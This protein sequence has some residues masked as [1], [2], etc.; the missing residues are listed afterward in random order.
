MT[1]AETTRSLPRM[2]LPRLAGVLTGCVGAFLLVAQPLRE[3]EAEAAR[4]VAGWFG[5]ETLALTGATT[6][7]VGSETHVAD[8][9]TSCSSTSAIIAVV[10][11]A[12]LI[13]RAPA[14]VRARGAVTAVVLLLMTNIVRVALVFVATAQ[15]GRTGLV[16]L[17]EWVGPVVTV[18]S[19]AI[20]FGWTVRQAAST[21][22]SRHALSR[23]ET[24]WAPQP[25]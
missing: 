14:I 8:L 24:A 23:S 5:V 9:T 4:R 12:I 11:L 20:A 6:A 10:T 7:I 22:G 21:T 1:V 25:V 13:R 16:V 2:L 17:H 15:W 18:C 3:L 19:F